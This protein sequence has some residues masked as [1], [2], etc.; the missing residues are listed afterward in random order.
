[1]K[2]HSFAVIGWLLALSGFCAW[3]SESIVP[4]RELRYEEVV[5]QTNW[6]ACGAAA[7]ATLLTHFYG[8]PTSEHEIL[9]LTEESMRARGEEP[10]PGHGLTAYDLKKALEAKGIET[11]GFRVTPEDLRDY[12]HRGGLPLILH[13]ARPQEHYLVVAGMIGEQVVLADP[14]WGRSIIPF[15]VL[16]EEKWESG[17]V[18]ITVPCAALSQRVRAQQE[19]TL[20]WA[21]LRLSRLASLREALP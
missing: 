9:S 6:Y 10:G 19:R 8:L 20:A 11:K 17:V 18:L 4:Y 5:G 14:S 16:A 2:W 7:V 12:F 1:M 3:G 15:S 21:A 13:V